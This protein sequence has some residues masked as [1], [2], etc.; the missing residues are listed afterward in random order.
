[1]KNLIVQ[2][3]VYR[4]QV[5]HDAN[6]KVTSE[7]QLMKLQYGIREWALFLKNISQMGWTKVDVVKC[8]DGNK[9]SLV[10]GVYQ[11]EEIDIPKEVIESIQIAMKASEKPMTADEKRIKDLEEQV[12]SLV[13]AGKPAKKAELKKPA[14]DNTPNVNEE[15]EAARDRYMEVF[16]GIKPKGFHMK[17]LATL[18]E[19]IEAELN[20]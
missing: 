15:L 9:K 19:E 6:G 7:N 17:K 18:N 1:M 5:N 11:L 16:K 14:K 20:K 4:G 10:K 13:A 3:R 8:L 12:A 2:L